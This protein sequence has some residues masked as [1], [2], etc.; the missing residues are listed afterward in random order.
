VTQ[1]EFDLTVGRS[2]RD[3]GITVAANNNAEA[4]AI[5]REEAR[6]IALECGRCDINTVQR[7]MQMRGLHLGNA[8]GSVFKG[9]E[10][11]RVGIGQATRVSSHARMISVWKLRA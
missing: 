11:E 7:V 9:K 10:W 1:P 4:L 6:K 8:A 3:A 2:E 5:A